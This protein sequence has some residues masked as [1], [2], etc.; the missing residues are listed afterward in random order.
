MPPGLRKKK[1]NLLCTSPLIPCVSRC[2]ATLS[3]GCRAVRPTA[4][5]LFLRQLLDLKYMPGWLGSHLGQAQVSD[6][7]YPL[8]FLQKV[9]PAPTVGPGL[10]P[11]ASGWGGRGAPLGPTR[12]RASHLAGSCTAGCSPADWRP[13][14]GPPLQSG[15]VPP[16]LTSRGRSGAVC[17]RHPAR[18]PALS[19]SCLGNRDCDGRYSSS[20]PGPSGKRGNAVCGQGGTVRKDMLSSGDAPSRDGCPPGARSLGPSVK[21]DGGRLAWNSSLLTEHAAKPDPVCCL[22][23]PSLFFFN[24]RESERAS[25]GQ[26]QREGERESRAG[27]MLSMEPNVG[28][29]PKPLGSRPELK[30]R[31]RRSTD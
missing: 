9:S 15:G 1:R 6:H 3:L 7:R 27:S 14:R 4:P 17:R 5:Q 26:G 23:Q 22:C 10:L 24:S 19:Q 31:A 30:S 25:R 12:A 18:W 16:R 29:D 11:L 2:A 21:V 20:L 28:L 8:P 13:R